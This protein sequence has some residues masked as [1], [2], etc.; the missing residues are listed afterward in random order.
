MRNR[1]Y[2]IRTLEN[3]NNYFKEIIST[4]NVII[5]NCFKDKMDDIYL[6]EC[7]YN[8]E[9]KF[10]SGGISKKEWKIIYDKFKNFTDL[11]EGEK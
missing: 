4:G 10:I 9:E 2:N 11:W 1:K 6:R 7:L 8:L 5:Y 3:Y